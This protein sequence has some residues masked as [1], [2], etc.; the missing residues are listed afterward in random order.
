MEPSELELLNIRN[1]YAKLYTFYEN[2]LAPHDLPTTQKLVFLIPQLEPHHTQQPP[3]S[4][5]HLQTAL[6][7]P[8]LAVPRYASWLNLIYLCQAHLECFLFVYIILDPR[9]LIESP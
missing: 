8:P 5:H 3:H 4:P 2:S 7:H 9:W 1:E 6:F